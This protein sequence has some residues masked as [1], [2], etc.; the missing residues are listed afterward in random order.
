LNNPG[1]GWGD[2]SGSG[3]S[4]VLHWPAALG[5]GYG[6]I[7]VICSTLGTE[8]FRP[9]FRGARPLRHLLQGL[10]AFETCVSAIT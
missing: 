6:V 7:G 9:P 5:A 4:A 3:A 1:R 8:H 10:S 2:R